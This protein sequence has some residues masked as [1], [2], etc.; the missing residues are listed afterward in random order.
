M[1]RPARKMTVERIGVSELA[2]SKRRAVLLNA[3]GKRTTR[4]GSGPLDLVL[5]YGALASQ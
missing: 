3:A 1:R 2:T 4:A 5:P